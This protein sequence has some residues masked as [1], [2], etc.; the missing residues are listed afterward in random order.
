[1][2]KL[3]T[4][5][6]WQA[7]FGVHFQLFR[8]IPVADSFFFF[9]FFFLADSAT[10]RCPCSGFRHAATKIAGGAPIAGIRS[11]AMRTTNSRT[12]TNF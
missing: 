1:V 8:V 7:A 9:F 11:Q 4:L 12:K 6:P 2:K 3:R 5:T 10:Q